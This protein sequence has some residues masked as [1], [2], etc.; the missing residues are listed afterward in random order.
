LTDALAVVA[1]QQPQGAMVACVIAAAAGRAF[2]RMRERITQRRFSTSSTRSLLQNALAVAARHQAH[3]T[4][5][6][7]VLAVAAGR[8]SLRTSSSGHAMNITGGAKKVG[9]VA[10]ADNQSI[11]PPTFLQDC[12]FSGIGVE[13]TPMLLDDSKARKQ[14]HLYAPGLCQDTSNHAIG[15]LWPAQ[16][17]SS[18]QVVVRSDGVHR[19]SASISPRTFETRLRQSA[20][21]FNDLNRISAVSLTWAQ[22]AERCGWPSAHAYLYEVP[23]TK[24]QLQERYAQSMR[25]LLL[26]DKLWQ[27]LSLSRATSDGDLQRELDSL[28]SH[29]VA[30]VP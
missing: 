25:Q 22:H 28:M 7:F 13:T 17:T 6:A 24:W 18:E 9:T 16:S 29:I 20:P 19:S 8:A 15:H 5:T 11:T 21:M 3:G 10:M 26:K 23:G 27:R 4:F 12:A 14:A 30:F 2:L 1:Q